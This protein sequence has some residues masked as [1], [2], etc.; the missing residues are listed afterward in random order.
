MSTCGRKLASVVYEKVLVRYQPTPGKCHVCAKF[1]RALLN[2]IFHAVSSG[3][4]LVFGVIVEK[5]RV[6]RIADVRLP[7]KHIRVRAEILSNLPQLATRIVLC[8]CYGRSR[9]LRPTWSTNCVHASD[10]NICW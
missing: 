4:F 5:R 2:K 8:R 1:D 10:V 3:A 6:T 7:R 9:I